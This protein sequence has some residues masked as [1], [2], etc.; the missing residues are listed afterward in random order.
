MLKIIGG[1][2]FIRTK[3]GKQMAVQDQMVELQDGTKITFKGGKI[4]QQSAPGMNR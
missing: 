3:A 4:L 2:V 1:Q